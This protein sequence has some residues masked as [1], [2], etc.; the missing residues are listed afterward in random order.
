[1]ASPLEVIGLLVACGSVAAAILAPNS[2]WQPAA[3]ALALVAAP[4]LVLGDV[5]DGPQV[6]DLRDSPAMIAAGLVALTVGVGVGALVMRRIEWAFPVLAFAALALRLPVRIGGET[7]NLLIPLYLVIASQLVATLVRE[8]PAAPPPEAAA[9]V[10]LR[11]ALAATLVLYAIQAAYSDDVSNAV[12]NVGFFLVPFAVLFCQLA[13]FRWDQRTL[14]AVGIAI[15]TVG[16]ALAI[17]AIVQ[18]GIRDLILNKDLLD[19]NQIKPFFRVN[20]VFFDPNVLGRYMALGT[21]AMG[22]AI[23]W[24]R[25]GAL[26][27]WATAAGVLMLAGLALSFSLTS[28]AAMLAGLGLLAL[29]RYGLIGAVAAGVAIV[30]TGVVLVLSGG[31]DRPDVGPSR[32]F[33]EETSGRGALLEGGFDLI[34]EE[35]I[36]GWGSGA[37]GRAYFDQ[38]ARTETTASHSEPITVAAEQGIPGVLVYLGLLA[39]MAWALLGGRGSLL[40]GPGRRRGGRRR[41]D[42]AQPGLRGLPHGPCHLGAAGGRHRPPPRVRPGKR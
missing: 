42:R 8:R 29:L 32:G 41:A 28:I 18:F 21:I 26:A 11:R 3:L 2:R 12:E 20:S 15:G 19:S 1:M 35:P 30:L 16:A 27:L 34:E 4:A 24:S 6:S 13:A 38:V 23:A 17:V 5:W 37:F 9:V 39:T 31:L 14:R 22:A 7:S 40:G 33:D 36:V 25:G 10:W